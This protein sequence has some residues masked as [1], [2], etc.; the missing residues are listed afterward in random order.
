MPIDY[1]I[2]THAKTVVTHF[3]GRV[4]FP[5]VVE[6]SGRLTSDPDF[7]P[8][9]SEV[10]DLSATEAFLAGFTETNIIAKHI[11]PFLPDSKRAIVATTAANIG[12]ARMYQMLRHDITT[13]RLFKSFDEAWEWLSPGGPH[14][15]QRALDREKPPNLFTES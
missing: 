4:T 8:E 9:Y 12:S 2:D 15:V 3:R 1:S 13:C 7:R 11:D 6:H 5:E 10:I 14:T